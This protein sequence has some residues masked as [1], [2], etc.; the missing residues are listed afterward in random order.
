MKK[1]GTFLAIAA[2]A[3]G[4]AQAAQGD[5]ETWANEVE[6]GLVIQF[7]GTGDFD[8]YDIGFGAEIQYRNWALDP[9]GV[10]FSVGYVQWEANEDCYKLGR[11]H[12]DF[13]GSVTTIPLGVSGLL[14]LY[15]SQNF[16]LI[17]EAGLRYL[18]TDSD[19][20]F[21][22]IVETEEG[23]VPSSLEVDDSVIGLLALEADYYISKQA[24]IF[25]GVGYQQDIER[26]AI[27]TPTGPLRDNEFT[28]LFIRLGG[29]IVF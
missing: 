25:G 24:L 28:S 14:Y 2:L 15:G 27:D 19:I 3:C 9:F 22:R 16:S 11:I 1:L 23:K 7:P 4:T 26:G 29:K 20:T 18:V 12:T 13:D 10:A 8:L 17:L 5:A 21:N 6:G